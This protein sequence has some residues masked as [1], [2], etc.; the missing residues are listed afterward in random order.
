MGSEGS[1]GS[2][3]SAGS[4]QSTEGTNGQNTNIVIENTR[5]GASPCCPHAAPH[6]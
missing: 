2:I 4:G 5:V 6:S 3:R 1:I